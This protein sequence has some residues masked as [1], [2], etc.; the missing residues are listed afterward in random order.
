VKGEIS[1]SNSGVA[2][3]SSPLEYYTVLL[4]TVPSPAKW[5]RRR[6]GQQLV[7]QWHSVITQDEPSP[8][9]M[10]GISVRSG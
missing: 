9:D 1:V 8:C 4:G 6:V 5:M 2:E 7:T 3:H 10:P